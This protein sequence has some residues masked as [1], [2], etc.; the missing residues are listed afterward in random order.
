MSTLLTQPLTVALLGGV[1]I[2]ILGELTGL[3]DV[4]CILGAGSCII[5]GVVGQ[6]AIDRTYD[7]DDDEETDWPDSLR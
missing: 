3:S 5:V 4:L 6:D 7:E 2:L 1:A